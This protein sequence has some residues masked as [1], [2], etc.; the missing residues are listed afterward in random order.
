MPRVLP[1]GRG[2]VAFRA[3]AGEE[4]SSCASVREWFA[5]RQRSRSATSSTRRY[6]LGAP[7]LSAT[8]DPTVRSP[9][10][11]V[12]SRA[13]FGLG[14]QIGPRSVH[15]RPRQHGACGG[16]GGRSDPLTAQDD[17]EHRRMFALD[18]P[19][20][21]LDRCAVDDQRATVVAPVPRVDRV[22][23][24]SA[25]CPCGEIEPERWPRS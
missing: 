4:S 6:G 13:Q 21:Q 5:S 11:S 10:I 23:R 1:V 24:P 12:L 3:I 18:L 22:L 7:E 20:R 8:L 15:G 2:N 25:Q 16:L 19:Y 17:L 9:S 14:S